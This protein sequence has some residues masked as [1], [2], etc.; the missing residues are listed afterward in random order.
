MRHFL[1]QS[2]YDGK[3]ADVVAEPDPLLVKRGIDAVGD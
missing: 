2:G 3:N 1:S